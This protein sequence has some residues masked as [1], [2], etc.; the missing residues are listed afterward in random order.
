M[1]ISSSCSKYFRRPCIRNELSSLK[2][3]LSCLRFLQSFVSHC[4][5]IGYCAGFSHSPWPT[6]DGADAESEASHHITS[7]PQS[8][9]DTLLVLFS[10]KCQMFSLP[11]QCTFK[12]ECNPYH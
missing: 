11:R 9:F 3:A 8:A 12:W 7:N 1:M 10:L 4:T 2:N 6:G 5:C